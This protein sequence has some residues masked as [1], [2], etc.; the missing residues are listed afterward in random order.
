MKKLVLVVLLIL[1]MTP[2]AFAAPGTEAA[3]KALIEKAKAEGKVTFLAN[4][5][6]IEPILAA[7][8][9][10][11][12]IQV[13]YTRISTTQF[14]PT[15]LA[16]HAA[17][18]LTADVLQAPRPVLDLLKERGVLASY[19]SPAAAGYPRWTNRDGKIQS[20]GIESAA[21]IYNKERVKAAEVPKTYQDLANPRWKGQI[22]MADPASHPTTIS[23]LVGL[24]ENV[25][26]SDAKWRK[27]L[28]GLAANSPMFV[29]SFGSTPAPIESGEK[30][31]GISMPKYIIT[32]AQAPLDWARVSQPLLGSPRGMAITARAL[33]PNAARLFMDYW[34]GKEAMKILAEQVG[35]YV[36]TP[37]I[38][39][40][41]A[42]IDKAKVIPIR[43]LT[44]DEI[45]K[46]GAEF[47]KIFA[48]P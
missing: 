47:K 39:P 45:Q 38:Y 31:I 40:P 44:D 4:I 19:R 3:D 1:A 36:L 18:K 20:F 27:F 9:K 8:E 17:G 24:R 30:L 2:R 43:E 10:K 15:I 16:E 41:I 32:R 5:T 12:G 37:G 34:L 28:K 46:R 23:W 22:V 21:L 25:I 35:E 14:L 26:Q 42:G 13:E 11:Y 7:F 48:T 6:A 33:H 29:A